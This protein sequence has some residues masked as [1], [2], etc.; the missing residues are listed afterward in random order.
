MHA[1]STLR[2]LFV[3]F[4]GTENIQES[5]SGVLLAHGTWCLFVLHRLDLLKQ[6]MTLDSNPKRALSN[7]L[8][9]CIQDLANID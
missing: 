3:S 9:Y 1:H 8:K 5:T 2:P 4:L 6:K 7:C